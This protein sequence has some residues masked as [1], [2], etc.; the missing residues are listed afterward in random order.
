ME[1]KIQCGVSNSKLS[2][3]MLK[4]GCADRTRWSS[5][6][7]L[8]LSR[9]NMPMPLSSRITTKGKTGSFSSWFLCFN[10][11]V[12]ILPLNVSQNISN[13]DTWSSLGYKEYMD[14]WLDRSVH[15]ASQFR[16]SVQGFLGTLSLEQSNIKVDIKKLDFSENNPAWVYFYWIMSI[17]LYS[18]QK[19]KT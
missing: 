3:M 1:P 8:D 14:L 4:Y 7:H 10:S 15:F 5:P 2:P 17:L 16:H 11:Q 12:F 13:S 9:T 6:T 18:G 19:R